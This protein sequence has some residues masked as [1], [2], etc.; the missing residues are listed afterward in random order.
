MKLIGFLEEPVVVTGILTQLGLPGCLGR[1]AGL[2]PTDAGQV[3]A[4]PKV[5]L[6]FLPAHAHGRVLP[7]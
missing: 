7:P 2:V 1:A 6:F 3:A 4:P 5:P